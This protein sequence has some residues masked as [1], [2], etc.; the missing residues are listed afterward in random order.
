MSSSTGSQDAELG[1]FIANL[2]DYKPTVPEAVSQYYLECS[3]VEIIDPRITKLVSL[4]TDKFIAEIIHEA[5]EQNILR[6]RN[7]K[8]GRRKADLQLDVIDVIDL[9]AS[10][11]QYNITWKRPRT[12]ANA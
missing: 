7:A 12:A 2:D 3:G 4:A 1:E 11:A 8:T 9:E 5:K 10:L 6:K